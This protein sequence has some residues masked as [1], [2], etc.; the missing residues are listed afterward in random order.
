MQIKFSIE[1]LP[2]NPPNTQ[3]VFDGRATTPRFTGENL[4]AYKMKIGGVPPPVFWE[5]AGGGL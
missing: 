4:V 3:W 1:P 2:K 5:G